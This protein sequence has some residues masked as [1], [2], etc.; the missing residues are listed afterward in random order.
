LKTMGTRI[1]LHLAVPVWLG[2][3]APAAAGLVLDEATAGDFSDD[4]LAP[5]SVTASPTAMTMAI[6]WPSGATAASKFLDADVIRL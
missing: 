1:S 2:L 5:T 3:A 6:S 4:R